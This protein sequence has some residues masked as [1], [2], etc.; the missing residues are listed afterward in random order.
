MVSDDQNLLA[1]T[2][3]YTG[4]RQYALQVKDL[5]TGQ[6][7]P[8]TAERVTSFEWAADNKTLFLTTEEQVTKRTDKLWR[9]VLG[10]RR[11]S[12]ST[13]R[14]TNSTTSASARRATSKYLILQIEAKDTTEVRYLRRRQSAGRTSRCFLPREKEH[15]YYLD[16]RE[17]LFYIRT[18]RTGRNFEI[19]TAPEQPAGTEE[20]EESSSRT[21]RTC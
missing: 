20:L 15:R 18:N 1:Y 14:R 2:I 8:D 10:S 17:D 16:H 3:D 19:V 7:L 11:S 13:T 5:R 9:H 6:T 4:F 12:R 21:A